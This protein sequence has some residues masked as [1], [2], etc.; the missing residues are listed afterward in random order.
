MTKEPVK[1]KAA[2]EAARIAAEKRA[3]AIKK[4]ETAIVH[5]I[6]EGALD[7]GCAV[8]HHDGEKYTS[9]SKLTKFTDK[10]SEME[11][12]LK[13]IGSN[14]TEMLRFKKNDKDI[15]DVILIYGNDGHDVVSEYT[16]NTDMKKIMAVAEELSKS[17]SAKSAA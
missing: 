17:Y 7:Y 14:E 4:I 15:G 10:E 9:F 13:E 11:R 12:I 1:N 6:V 3:E 5:A 8:L 2:I 16:E